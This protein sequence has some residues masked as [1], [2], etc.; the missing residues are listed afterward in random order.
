MGKESDAGDSGSEDG[1]DDG[2]GVGL[3]GRSLRVYTWIG[4]EE[5]GGN[6]TDSKRYG[7]GSGIDVTL[8]SRV[9]ALEDISIGKRLNK[10][11]INA[12]KVVAKYRAVTTISLMSCGI[13][14]ED[15]FSR[16][17]IKFII[18]RTQVMNIANTPKNL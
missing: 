1:M 4:A 15:T 7:T 13:T 2:G 6:M 5:H 18:A 9:D 3:D 8:G 14:K 11:D 17:R 12:S 16:A 10:C